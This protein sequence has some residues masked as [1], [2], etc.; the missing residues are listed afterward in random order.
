[1]SSLLDI[2]RLSMG[3][4][5]NYL[6]PMPTGPGDNAIRR[7]DEEISKQY[8]DGASEQKSFLEVAGHPVT[9]GPYCVISRG[10]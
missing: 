8:G 6:P 9:P 5:P 1:M 3:D 2:R 7:S 10:S 4:I